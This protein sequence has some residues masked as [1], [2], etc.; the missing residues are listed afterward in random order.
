MK[1]KYILIHFIIIERRIIMKNEI[2]YLPVHMI[3]KGY[4][5][6]FD[7][8]RN[9]DLIT[10]DK[11]L[12]QIQI[13]NEFTELKYEEIKQIDVSLCSIMDFYTLTKVWYTYHI[14]ITIQDIHHKIYFLECENDDVFIP[15]LKVLHDHNIL[16]E[17]KFD[18]EKIYLEYP[19]KINRNKYFER[20]MKKKAKQLNIKYPTR[21]F[22]GKIKNS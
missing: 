13:K 17:D 19:D 5:I 12:L 14:F 15:F 20:N 3:C 21:V 10:V 22:M 9:Y 1:K 2:I 7:T 11:D 6:S 4:E 8:R 18:L 16:I